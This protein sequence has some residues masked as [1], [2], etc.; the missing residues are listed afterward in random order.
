MY[1]ILCKVRGDQRVRVKS[2]QHV[3]SEMGSILGDVEEVRD[4]EESKRMVL[5][6]NIG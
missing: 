1:R 4:E 2:M 3:A 6:M 5:I